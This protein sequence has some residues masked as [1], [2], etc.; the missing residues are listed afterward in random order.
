VLTALSVFCES[1][2]LTCDAIMKPG[3]V[4]ASILL[5]SS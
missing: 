4:P 1:T 3:A 5:A 2:T